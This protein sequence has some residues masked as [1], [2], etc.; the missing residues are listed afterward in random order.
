MR[1][2][3]AS[4]VFGSLFVLGSTAAAVAQQP[5]TWV[6]VHGPAGWSPS[7]EL[8]LQLGP[9]SWHGYGGV[10]SVSSAGPARVRLVARE[11]CHVYADFVAP[12]G[13]M[14]VIRFQPDGSVQIED[15]T[16]RGMDSGPALSQ[17]APAE[18]PPASAEPAAPAPADGGLGGLVTVAVLGGVALV[19]LVGLLMFIQ[20]RSSNRPR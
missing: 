13:T 12:V 19:L 16:A 8:V 10:V 1:F 11:S 15:W 3:L 18:C 17:V 2:V 4:L 9:T 20:S 5:Q 14:W 7:E 6:A